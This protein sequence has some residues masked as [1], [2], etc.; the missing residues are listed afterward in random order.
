MNTIMGISAKHAGV[1]S[2][3]SLPG[4]MSKYAEY[5]LCLISRLVHPEIV[6]R[7]VSNIILFYGLRLPLSI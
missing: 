6:E 7:R 2:H 3:S 5:S 4:L 1:A